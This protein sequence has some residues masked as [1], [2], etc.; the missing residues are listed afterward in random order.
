MA[1]LRVGEDVAER[2]VLHERGERKPGENAGEEPGLLL[3]VLFV[4]VVTKVEALDRWTLVA[5]IAGIAAV[6]FGTAGTDTAQDLL[7]SQDGILFLLAA[8]GS[9]ACFL[10]TGQRLDRKSVV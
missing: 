10:A 7:T 2:A 4:A 6:I 5:L 9:T 8:A 1:E 3:A